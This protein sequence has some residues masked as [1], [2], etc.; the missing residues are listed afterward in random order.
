MR[1]EAM[2]NIRYHSLYFETVFHWW[3]MPSRLGWL[4]GNP[5]TWHLPPPLSLQVQIFLFQLLLKNS[6]AKSCFSMD[7]L[8]P[9]FSIIL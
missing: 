7:R 6:P 9:S 2:V 3:N 8:N 4:A 1:V 5:G